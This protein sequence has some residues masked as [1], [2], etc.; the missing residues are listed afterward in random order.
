MDE[1]RYAELRYDDDGGLR[2]PSGSSGG[3]GDAC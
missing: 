2:G 3:T 1:G